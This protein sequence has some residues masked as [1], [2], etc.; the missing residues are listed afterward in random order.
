MKMDRL[1]YLSYSYDK[2]KSPNATISNDSRQQNSIKV[3][4]KDYQHSLLR[5]Q[6]CV[7]LIGDQ[8]DSVWAMEIKETK[9]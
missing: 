5:N 4:D 1:D 6:S 2:H 9:L 8:Q 7:C 3:L